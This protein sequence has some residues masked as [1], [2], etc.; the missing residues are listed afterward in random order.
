MQRSIV[1]DLIPDVAVEH[2]PQHPEHTVLVGNPDAPTGIVGMTVSEATY[3]GQAV[4]GPPIVELIALAPAVA[5]LDPKD[6]RRNTAPPRPG[7]SSRSI[8]WLAKP[9]KQIGASRQDPQNLTLV[10]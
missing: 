3:R 6:P 7:S 8:A 5:P 2:V 10:V 9:G 4:S 1:S